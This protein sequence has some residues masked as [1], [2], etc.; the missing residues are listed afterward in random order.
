MKH[1]PK[2][3]QNS[4]YDD[5]FVKNLVPHNHPLLEIDR[6]VDFSFV[7]E[8]VE[9]LYSPNQGRE[10]ID[11]ALLLRL[12]FVQVYY[13]LSDREV[14]DRAQTDL[15]IRCFLH[16]GIED[17]LPDSSTLSVF[18]SRLGPDRFR[19]IFEASIEQARDAGLVGGR[20]ILVDSWGIQMD[21]SAPRTR[22]LL[23]RVVAK[24]VSLLQSLGEDAS[25]FQSRQARLCNDNSW[26][27]TEKLRERD[28]HKWFVLADDLREALGRSAVDSEHSVEARNDM[29]YLLEGVIARQESGSGKM[30]T[31]VDPDARWSKRERG[32]QSHPGYTEQS[33][34]DADSEILVGLKVTAANKDDSTQFQPLLDQC[35]ATVGAV[36]D[37]VAADSGYH[38]GPN[39]QWLADEGIDDFI[40]PPTPKGHKKGMYSA[41]DFTPS[42]DENGR[43]VRIRCPAGESTEGGRWQEEK[44][45]WQFYFTKAQCQGCVLR[46][47]C[48]R[49]EYGRHV[50]ISQYFDLH[51]SAREREKTEEF[52]QA[53]IERLNIERTFAYQQGKFGMKR[54]RYR[55]LD[56]VSS[57]VLL[58]GFVINAVRMTNR[59]REGPAKS[60]KTAA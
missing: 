34:T 32:K 35:V 36:P 40:A 23:Q 25:E 12:C 59:L 3:E 14:I 60:V 41:P 4:L 10:A 15:A 18:R 48:S 2:A 57:G 11:P 6:V 26:G 1:Q 28:L 42:F 52:Q 45:G 54:T 31:D 30:I 43:P 13:D 46:D 19:Q 24:A 16:L 56:R 9:D 8:V 53:Q 21:A 33:A 58:A 27:L 47:R 22:T 37:S 51:Q 5:Y 39:R 20:R 49:S 29:L 17:K 50:F 7:R 55:G 38:S 44:A